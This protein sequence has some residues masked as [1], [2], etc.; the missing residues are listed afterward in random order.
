MRA[1]GRIGGW[2]LAERARRCR[3]LCGGLAPRVA[4]CAFGAGRYDA[5][6][7]R[8]RVSWE[9]VAAA[10]HGAQPGARGGR[11]GVQVRPESALDGQIT[12]R[13]PGAACS[14][15]APN[16]PERRQS[17]AQAVISAGLIAGL[18]APD[19]CAALV[20]RRSNVCQVSN[21][22]QTLVKHWSNAIQPQGG[23]GQARRAGG[24]AAAAR[25]GAAGGRARGG[26]RRR[27]GRDSSIR[28]MNGDQMWA[29]CWFRGAREGG[30]RAGER[31]TTAQRWG[32]FEDDSLDRGSIV[33]CGAG[34]GIT[35]A[36][37]RIV[38]TCKTIN[39][40][41]TSRRSAPW[42]ASCWPSAA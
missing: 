24:P 20:K 32:Q 42:H 8:A 41:S 16:R 6:G 38:G 36:W 39:P 4:S 12:L 5:R 26:R 14:R 35:D 17:A 33:A 3:D 19:R 22:R 9:G 23:Q 1:R 37:L 2:A 18:M 27:G 40:P 7:P 29:V 21:V 15:L 11:P 10:V 30:W 28:V 13:H 31:L 34:Q 25:G